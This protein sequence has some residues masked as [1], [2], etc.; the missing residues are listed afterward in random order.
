[1]TFTQKTGM[2]AMDIKR[3]FKPGNV[4][5]LS[6]L[7]SNNATVEN[8]LH[9]ATGYMQ[10]LSFDFNLKNSLKRVNVVAQIWGSCMIK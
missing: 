7:S 3:Y 8:T 6:A 9:Q 4:E 2:N 10:L 1:M 5:T